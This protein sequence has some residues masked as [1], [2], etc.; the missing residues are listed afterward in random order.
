M[1][2]A[3]QIIRAADFPAAVAVT[4]STTQANMANTSY[5]AG[6]P[7]CSLTF[8][9]ATSGR[10]QI[11]IWAR[12]QG[13]GTFRAFLGFELYLG[14]SSSGTLIE[15][16]SDSNAAQTAVVST[17]SAG[18][19]FLA[20]GLTAGAT[21]YVRTMQKVAGGTTADIFTRRITVTPTT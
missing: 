14:T 15:A 1:P 8:V 16:V 4:E 6:T 10:A 21:Y 7:A 18:I 11:D 17:E 9:A 13:D 20:T 19:S 2:N 12:M 5:A 3:G